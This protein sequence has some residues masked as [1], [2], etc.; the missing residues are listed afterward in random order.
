MGNANAHKEGSGRIPPQ[1]GLQA[2]GEI[3]S[4]RMGMC[5]SV[6]PAVG[7]DGGGGLTGG[8][9]LRLLPPEHSCTVH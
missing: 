3:T 5:M 1:G 6:S 4:K 2:D 8:G 9:D 7:R